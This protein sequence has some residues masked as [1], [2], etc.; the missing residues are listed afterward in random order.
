MILAFRSNAVKYSTPDLYSTVWVSQTACPLLSYHSV[1]LCSVL[2]YAP[3]SLH[4]SALFCFFL[5]LMLEQHNIMR[6]HVLSCDLIQFN[7]WMG[8]GCEEDKAM[9]NLCYPYYWYR[10]RHGYSILLKINRKQL[11]APLCPFCNSSHPPF[12]I[13]SWH[14]RVS[15]QHTAQYSTVQYSTVQFSSVQYSSVLKGASKWLH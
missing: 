6:Y 1:L 3:S 10:E 8:D 7:G 2:F 11:I 14:I 13:L 4:C 15:T 5:S 9:K 12:L